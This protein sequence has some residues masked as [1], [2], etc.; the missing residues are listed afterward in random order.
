VRTGAHGATEVRG[1]LR[2]LETVVCGELLQLICLQAIDARVT[3]VENMRGRV[4][5]NHSAEGTHVPALLVIAKLAALGLRIQPGIERAQHPQRGCF[6]RP[7][8]GG[9]VIIGKKAAYGGFAGDVTDIAAADPVRHRN[10]D[11]LG[12]ALRLLRQTGAKKILIKRFSALGGILPDRN[13]QRL[14]HD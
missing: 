6:D 9:A 5:D 10:A 1:V 12:A 13:K 4:F 7:G 8:F 11:T 14:R 3:G 2:E